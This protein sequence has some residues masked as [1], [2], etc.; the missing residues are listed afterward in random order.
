M[1]DVPERAHCRVKS[2]TSPLLVATP[3][4]PT[5][6]RPY[7]GAFV[8]DW[9]KS[10]VEMGLQP[11][12]VHLDYVTEE[13]VPSTT[14]RSDHGVDV[15]HVRVPVAADPTPVQIAHAYADALRPLLTE[16][17][18][19]VRTIHAHVMFP[20]GW[21]VATTMAPGTRLVV[22]EHTS[23]LGF[24]FSKDDTK[25]M[26]V[27]ALAA[28]RACLT[29]S[30]TVTSAISANVPETLA[31]RVHTV[32]NPVAFER[33]PLQPNR[34][35]RLHRWLYLGNLVE[36]KGIDRTIAA[37][38]LAK[39]AETAL[40]AVDPMQLTIVGDGPLR[41]ELAD[42]AVAL[43]VADD[44][45]FVDGVAA[46]KVPGVIAAHDVL[47]H[48]SDAETF[49][50]T[51]IEAVISGVPVLTTRSGGPEET[52]AHAAALH[53]VQFVPLRA[54][55]ALVAQSYRKLRRDF[56]DADWVTIR[57]LLEHRYS[58]AAIGEALA[59]HLEDR[60]AQSAEPPWRRTICISVGGKASPSLQPMAE[61]LS[62]AG[63]H[64][65]MVNLATG[66]WRATRH[67]QSVAKRVQEIVAAERPDLV[68]V[69][70][71]VSACLPT[72]RAKLPPT[73]SVSQSSRLWRH[74]SQ[75]LGNDPRLTPLTTNGS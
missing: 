6:D 29:V 60:S 7:Y 27:D 56:L 61:Q 8:V 39:K 31:Q 9:V 26:Y 34:D 42:Q 10:L 28:T 49:G 17:W 32:G 69:D 41:A 15:V 51:A 43:G 75:L 62:S 13:S 44:V 19:D 68:L 5:P 54:D 20:L 65:A 30:S 37:F 59:R 48:L 53:A 23:K 1:N 4:Y 11:T 70:E 12:V 21:A 55:P 57:R 72:V 18:A 52:L 74:L 35:S 63:S 36:G 33:F 14:E 46:E 40:D 38:A 25:Q 24:Y 64:V 22:T 45:H 71:Y 66:P 58:R 2:V 16:R 67:P 73:V 50:K 47:V 3:W